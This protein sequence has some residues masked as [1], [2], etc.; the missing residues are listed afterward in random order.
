ML[1]RGDG[2][3]IKQSLRVHDLILF[4]D[5]GHAGTRFKYGLILL[6]DMRCICSLP[7][8]KAML[9]HGRGLVSISFPVCLVDL[10]FQKLSVSLTKPLCVKL[11]SL[12]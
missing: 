6:H 1:F 12:C 10:T 11:S 8:V 7:L 3:V 2:A 9:R 5:H 4:A